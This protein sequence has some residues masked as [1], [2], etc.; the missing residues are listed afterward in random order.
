VDDLNLPGTQMAVVLA[1]LPDDVDR[2]QD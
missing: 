2:G 1:G